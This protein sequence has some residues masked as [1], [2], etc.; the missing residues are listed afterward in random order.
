MKMRIIP[1]ALILT[2]I[3]GGIV[4]AQSQ[5][6]VLTLEDILHRADLARTVND[7]VLAETK[8]S[9]KSHSVFNRV[10]GD[11]NIK[12]SDTTIVIITRIGDEEISREILYTSNGDQGRKMKRREGKIPLSPDNPDYDFSLT[13]GN[14]EIYRVAVVP[15]KS[16]PEKG[17]YQGSIEIDSEDYSIR[18]IDFVVPR[19]EG[20]LKEFAI[21]MNFKPLEGGLVVPTDMRI[22]GY[23]KALLGIVKVRFTGEILFSD[24]QILE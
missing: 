7:S 15:R 18:R 10:D 19:P 22:R 11:G 14:D 17:D 2:L 3:A 12:S 4:M 24:Y 9:F 20:A 5:V 6:R 8:F 23:V 21:D 1:A 13:G 16:P